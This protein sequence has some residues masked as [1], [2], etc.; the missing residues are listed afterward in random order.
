MPGLQSLLTSFAITSNGN[1][2]N[3][4]TVFQ[5]PN[6]DVRIALA[7][8]GESIQALANYGWTASK[9]SAAP[10]FSV[11]PALQRVYPSL[12]SQHPDHLAKL[13]TSNTVGQLIEAQPVQHRGRMARW[14]LGRSRS[15]GNT[16]LAKWTRDA[17]AELPIHADHPLAPTPERPTYLQGAD[18]VARIT[19]SELTGY[20]LLLV[21]TSNG[22]T[23]LSSAPTLDE[24]WTPNG[25]WT[26]AQW[27]AYEQLLLAMPCEASAFDAH[28][29]A[30]H[31]DAASHTQHLWAIEQGTAAYLGNATDDLRRRFRH[32][33]SSQWLDS[34]SAETGISLKSARGLNRL[35]DLFMVEHLDDSA[36][37]EHIVPAMREADSD[38]A[39]LSDVA[40]AA[41]WRSAYNPIL[42]S[43]LRATDDKV[44]LRVG[45]AQPVVKS[46]V[47]TM[48]SQLS[49]FYGESPIATLE[50]AGKL[51]LVES[52]DD[53]PP[54][55]RDEVD[56]HGGR[57]RVSGLESEGIVYLIGANTAP[58]NVCSVFLH[59]VGEHAALHTM[60]GRDYGRI[61][62]RF[63]QLLAEGDT[64]A[65]QASML[66]PSATAPSNLNSEHL[67]HLIQLTADDLVAKDG[68]L[69]GFDL[70]QRCIRDLRTWLYRTPLMREL[71]RQGELEDFKLEA[72]DIATLARE[73]VDF[74]V[75][76]HQHST[77]ALNQWDSKLDGEFVATLHKMSVERRIEALQP[78]SA[79]QQVAYLYALGTMSAPNGH[80]TLTQ[81]A[82]VIAEATNSA[83]EVTRLIAN[84]VSALTLRLAT[85]SRASRRL[86]DHGLFAAIS[87]THDPATSVLTLIRSAEQGKWIAEHYQA[88][89]GLTLRE[90]FASKDDAVQ[91]LGQHHFAVQQGEMNSVIARWGSAIAAEH[92][93][94]DS[95]TFQRWFSGSVAKHSDGSPIVMYHG[96]AKSFSQ[97]NGI[98][99]ASAA[100]PAELRP[101]PAPAAEPAPPA[102]SQ[103][104]EWFGSS[105]IVDADGKPL[106]LYHGTSASFNAFKVSKY[107]AIGAGVYTTPNAGEAQIYGDRL[108]DLNANLVNP[109]IG[110]FAEIRAMQYANETSEKFTERLI[111]LGYDGVATKD[112]TGSFD[113]VVA[114]LPEQLKSASQNNGMYDRSNPDIRFRSEAPQ[115][116]PTETLAFQNW[117][118]KSVIKDAHGQPLVVFHGTDADFTAFRAGPSYFSPRLDYSFVRNSD[119]VMPVYL[120]I[121]NPYRPASQQEIE[122]IRSNPERY[123]ELK[124]QGYDGMIWSKPDDIMKG[125]SGWGNDLPQI[126]AFYPNQ[127]KSALGNAGTFDRASDDIR[128]DM[129]GIASQIEQSAF[130]E[131]FGQSLLVNGAG[132]PL[133]LYHGTNKDF[134]AFDSNALNSRYPLSFGFHFTDSRQ[135]ASIYADSVSNAATGFNPADKFGKPPMEGGNVMPVFIRAE[136]PLIINTDQLTASMEADRNREQILARLEEAKVAGSPYDSVIIKRERGDEYDGINVI[137]FNPTQIKSATANVG[138]FDRD[139]A[140]IRFNMPR[141]VA[142]TELP[143][144]K[145]WFE[146]SQV[147]DGTGKPLVVFHGTTADI[148][149][150]IPQYGHATDQGVTFFTS[151][152][153]LASD[154]A[155]GGMD[156]DLAAVNAS[157]MERMRKPD[158]D[159][160]SDEAATLQ[161][162]QVKAL[163]ELEVA[164]QPAGASVIPVYLSMRNPLVVASETMTY[165]EQRDLFDRAAAAGHDGVIVRA[166]KDG[167]SDRTKAITSDV[168]AVF[169]G[170]QIKSAISNVGSFDRN[171][172][173]I[174]FKMGGQLPQTNQPTFKDWF[175]RS[176]VVTEAG[177]PLVVFHGSHKDF[178][179]FQQQE[180]AHL[181]FHFGNQEAANTRL[182]D[183]AEKYFDNDE[184]LR[185]NER[186][187]MFYM[188]L[189]AF[190][191]TLEEKSA[192]TSP[193]TII[194]DA[195]RLGVE[196]WEI[197]GDYAY[198]PTSQ[199]L[200]RRQELEN[201]FNEANVL[202]HKYGEGSHINAFYLSI[203]R[204]LRLPDVG[205]WGTPHTVARELPW[206]SDAETFE[207]IVAEIKG[208][209]YDGIVY[210]NKVENM[211]GEQADSY[212]AFDP[213][214]IKSAIGNVG[215]FDKESADVRFAFAGAGAKTASRQLLAS[216]MAT[217]EAGGDAEQVRQETSW[218]QG[219]DDKW[220]FELDDSQLKTRESWNLWGQNKSAQT[221]RL[222]DLIDHWP[223][224]DAYPELRYLSVT[225]EPGLPPDHGMFQPLDSSITVGAEPEQGLLT[226]SAQQLSALMHE[227]QHGIQEIEKFSHGG[228]SSDTTLLPSTAVL[229]NLNAIYREREEAA[230]QSPEYLEYLE[231]VLS[232]TPAGERMRQSPR[233][234]YD[235]GMKVALEA[236]YNRYLDPID[237]ERLAMFDRLVKLE[238]P[239]QGPDS[240]MLSYRLLAGEV[241]ARNVQSRLHLTAPE[242]VAMSPQSTQDAPEESVYLW[243]EDEV[244][245]ASL[246]RAQNDQT[247]AL[248]TPSAK[249][250]FA[251]SDNG[252]RGQMDALAD[253]YTQS[254]DY[255][256]EQ[257]EERERITDQLVEQLASNEQ[258][259]GMVLPVAFGFSTLTQSA[260]QPGAW[261]VT[262]LDANFAPLSDEGTQSKREALAT[263]FAHFDTASATAVISG[264]TADIQ[265]T[266]RHPGLS[267]ALKGSTLA[268]EYAEMRQDAASYSQSELEADR[269]LVMPVYLSAES[270][271][272]GDKLPSGSMK[273]GALRDELVRQ[274]EAAGRHIDVMLVG[275]LVKTITKA[276]RAEESGPYYV[277]HDFWA[278]RESLFGGAGAAALEQLFRHCGFDSIKLT[279]RDHLTYGVFSSAQVKSA[280][281]NSGLYSA[282]PD[283][284]FSFAGTKALTSDMSRLK[285][286]KQLA[287]QDEPADS[288]WSQTGWMVG[289][290]DAWRFEIDDSKAR[291]RGYNFET[292]EPEVTTTEPE[293]FVDW[294]DESMQR[295]N[296]VPLGQFYHHPELY[297]A[298]PRLAHLNVVAVERAPGDANFGTVALYPSFAKTKLFVAAPYT[299]TLDNPTVPEILSHEIQHIIQHLEGFGPGAMIS[300]FDDATITSESLMSSMRAYV[301]IHDQSKSLGCEP[302]KFAELSGHDPLLIERICTW[303]QQGNWESNVASFRRS[304]MTPF[305]LYFHEAG[306]VEARNTSKRLGM[307]AQQR[308]SSF[309]IETLDVESSLVRVTRQIRVFANASAEPETAAFSRADSA[310]EWAIKT[311]SWRNGLNDNAQLIHAGESINLF[312]VQ[313][314][315]ASREGF[316]EVFAVALDDTVVGSFLY[317]SASARQPHSAAAMVHPDYRRQGIATA[318]YDAI[319]RVAGVSLVPSVTNTSD[320]ASAFWAA[321][322][323]S[324]APAEAVGD[325]NALT[326]WLRNSSTVDAQ[327]KPITFFHGTAAAFRNF[328]AARH[329]SILNNNYQGDA[330][331]FT[332]SPEVASEYSTAARNQ[333]F[334][335]HDLFE[336]ADKAMPSSA[337]NLLKGLVNEGHATWEKYS[338]E[339]MRQF[340]DTCLCSGIDLNDLVDLSQYVEGSASQRAGEDYNLFAQYHDS[341]MPEHIVDIAVSLGLADAVPTPI[342]MPVYLRCENTLYTND[343]E[344]AREAQSKGYDSVC[345]SGED[346]VDQEPEWLVFSSQNIR[347][348]FEFEQDAKVYMQEQ[349]RP[350]ATP[351]SA[352]ITPPASTQFDHWFEGS[353]CINQFGEPRL[354]FVQDNSGHTFNTFTDLHAAS[355]DDKGRITPALLAIRSPFVVTDSAHIAIS[356]LT[357]KLGSRKAGLI[358]GE[359]LS[360]GRLAVED[361]MEN[362]RCCKWLQ[363]A[364][365]DG[366]IYRNRDGESRYA[367]FDQSQAVI[368]TAVAPDLSSAVQWAPVPTAVPLTFLGDR[369]RARQFTLSNQSK[370]HGHVVPMNAAEQYLGASDR[371]YVNH[372]A[373]TRLTATSIAALSENP[374]TSKHLREF[375][376]LNRKAL[377][378]K[379]RIEETFAEHIRNLRQDINQT[380]H[381]ARIDSPQANHHRS[382]L[383]KL[384]NALA[385]AMEH[386]GSGKSFKGLVSEDLLQW[387]K[388][389][390]QQS[391]MV[392]KALATLGIDGLYLVESNGAA[393]LKTCSRYTAEEYA[394][395]YPDGKVVRIDGAGLTGR[396]CYEELANDLGGSKQAAELLTSMGITGAQQSTAEVLLFK[397]GYNHEPLLAM[398]ISKMSPGALDGDSLAIHDLGGVMLNGSVNAACK[399]LWSNQER[400]LEVAQSAINLLAARQAQQG[401]FASPLAA[402][403]GH[404]KQQLADARALHQG[405]MFTAIPSDFM[406]WNDPLSEQ[407]MKALAPVIQ[408]DPAHALPGSAIF[409]LIAGRQ[410]G[411]EGAKA[412]LSKAGFAGVCSEEY[413]LAW[414][415]S[416][417][418]VWRTVA[419]D[420]PRD[421]FSA[422]TKQVESVRAMS[423]MSFG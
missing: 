130:R 305:E 344:Q 8:D 272:D 145:A 396:A 359:L 251:Y 288:I 266:S 191:K 208:Y 238:G 126:V 372:Y 16:E 250:R 204:P 138:S 36:V 327:G 301:E 270:P 148:V 421:D 200:A 408:I 352:T 254:D 365:Y 172:A 92:R 419:S 320:S 202:A 298:Y 307:D 89:L 46:S 108:I 371:L 361:I 271:F 142:Q 95:Q 135:E 366:A 171:S 414:G 335:Q 165:P 347:S 56:L 44:R 196:I 275:S 214:Q 416:A 348:V 319:E 376:T 314:T 309:P 5:H 382:M 79:D 119:V 33:P 306:E 339:D 76:D 236:A 47:D 107:G 310:F 402:N 81:M 369:A 330:F 318:A 329:R 124:V 326:K 406:P 102:P 278:N 163:A 28:V 240:R 114:F 131:W 297:A 7:A 169:N 299:L 183:T 153:E 417:E 346:T 101:E 283:I 398:S 75:A 422:A 54:N 276:A 388:P 185:L 3:G 187:S 123:E 226:L 232:E 279:E 141:A 181:G 304:L 409:R 198:Q 331:H 223:L 423:S 132:A 391:P 212:I 106:T 389:L 52:V 24:L 6:T 9:T 220:R 367:T 249:L 58:E 287:E 120:N 259:L 168:F 41:I 302:E 62:N 418:T 401:E 364:G 210:L 154:Y 248:P 390:S 350:M 356:D 80:E 211:A 217:M 111:G 242:R 42:N 325:S 23:M 349:N 197:I 357:N 66:V 261:Q 313:T 412:M 273:V 72:H 118:D 294:V 328:D 13:L 362:P 292:D 177:D 360:D 405:V 245:L 413:T 400:A 368:G 40:L 312:S 289:T 90:E 45:E 19:G 34:A 184:Y 264:T 284:R 170:S 420:V 151:N 322:Q 274:A 403:Y 99:W 291:V 93:Q 295:P 374:A 188:D 156:R 178:T 383:D 203:Q 323:A 88:G 201:R 218:F 411:I 404:N 110:T 224:F 50:L 57:D 290:D 255:Q 74:Y 333:F 353:N 61:V 1:S 32:N 393:Q 15:T 11:L 219:S 149:E 252:I 51:R 193:E 386:S 380:R 43:V 397:P 387:N 253:F 190:N 281:G 14:L 377:V 194:A 199:E 70:G 379:A 180:G 35:I 338:E 206:D 373:G 125:A 48:R 150:F 103:F 317:C 133:M 262:A 83:D 385:W 222:H 227:V 21:A 244:R 209:G 381:E 286:A 96:T 84:E 269:A 300:D 98:F 115:R 186:A 18:T 399:S 65:V 39:E 340:I 195:A 25:E 27:N 69:G 105:K 324:T 267:K 293:R 384:S 285:Q 147:V 336:A 334:R 77:A 38:F 137:V 229:K 231:Q 280:S 4:E 134:T 355:A 117:F 258:F 234:E 59:E 175:V 257:F 337:S 152:P 243:H 316:G 85:Q 237:E 213:E 20:K 207:D 37:L 167:A 116:S 160:L 109:L 30:S 100:T 22:R 155:M 230:K 91:I 68:G 128:F 12:Q 246:V 94:L 71:E 370:P 407:Q 189:Q 97:A 239:L 10:S 164:G 73:A 55:L 363:Q 303:R 215:T 410:D 112:A 157:L 166:T 174:R 139:S 235:H 345:Y 31:T 378:G 143:A 162:A 64:Y 179:V 136:N 268:D 78:L 158:F 282:N 375:L 241:E 127:V 60:L 343:R 263:F 351:V 82:G 86:D 113:Y 358:V 308:A 144:F 205:D 104:A 26:T 182:D 415:S 146:S 122:T 87:G 394:L 311:D 221:F 129:P 315:A 296:G 216:A 321:R 121:Q 277:R 341:D 161:A 247:P 354:V 29:N 2:R 49:S 392:Q 265:L 233:G 176:K 395:D 228:S 140:D 17:C 53:L 225:V 159:F 67:A 256:L 342:V 260:K 173:D 63:N 192:Y 332:T